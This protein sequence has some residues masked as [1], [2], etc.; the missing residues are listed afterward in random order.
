MPEPED[1]PKNSYEVKQ[2]KRKE[3]YE[4]LAAK[5]ERESEASF[6]PLG[7]PIL[8]GH[9]SERR[10]RRDLARI[11]NNMRRAIEASEKS[12]YYAH[13]AA[14]VGKGGISSDDPDAIEKLKMRLAEL[15]AYQ[16]EMK[17][18]NKQ[19]PGTY[20]GYALQNNNANIRRIRARIVDLEKAATRK[21]TV[22]KLEGLTIRHDVEEN[23]VMLRFDKKPTPEILALCKKHGFKWAPSHRANVRLLNDAAIYAAEIVSQAFLKA[24]GKEEQRV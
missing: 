17:A 2:Q 8:V 21:T 5:A 19:A 3:R 16:A 12:G 18:A 4:Q 13:K 14:S 6:I 22:I 1:K 15:E 10:H 11:D 9:H 20:P 7:Q 24:T 23:R